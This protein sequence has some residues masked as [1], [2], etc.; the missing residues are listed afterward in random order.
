MAG[1]RGLVCWRW[2]QGR[3]IRTED[4]HGRHA[5]AGPPRRGPLGGTRRAVRR[6]ARRRVR[7]DG[8]PPPRRRPSGPRDQGA[9]RRHRS[10]TLVA[11]LP[12]LP[13]P[14]ACFDA[15]VG[16]FVLGHAGPTQ[17]VVAELFRVVRPGGR[18]GLTGWTDVP[19]AGQTPLGRALHAAGAP[20][21]A[22]DRLRPPHSDYPGDAA[23][24]AGLLSSAG[25]RQA[26]CRAVAWDHRV[27]AAAWSEGI[28]GLLGTGLLTAAPA[29][30]ATVTR[31]L[32]QAAALSTPFLSPDG[33][34]RLAQVR[35]CCRTGGVDPTR[36]R[37]DHRARPDRWRRGPRTRRRG[38][39]PGRARPAAHCAPR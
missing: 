8:G 25:L 34:L 22:P 13:F 37:T 9:G 28:A 17:A 5:T 20:R 19:A 16:N 29:D 27:G 7:R 30:P 11:A 32:R 35:R 2:R 10:R 33:D 23:G 15:V 39:S 14:D 6:D 3:R 26:V 24:M 18:V 36:R 31:I 12:R 38:P 1:H 21:V 4:G